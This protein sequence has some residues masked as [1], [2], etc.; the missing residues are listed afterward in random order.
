MSDVSAK[1]IDAAQAVEVGGLPK[2]EK[3]RYETVTVATTI[4]GSWHN[5]TMYC[6]TDA[7][8]HTFSDLIPIGFKM[9]IENIATAGAA[10][11]SIKGSATVAIIGRNQ[12]IGGT[13]SV[14]AG[15]VGKKLVNTKGTAL[16]YDYVEVE[17][18]SSTE[19]RAT[20]YGIWAKEV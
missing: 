10:D 18:I 2:I 9:R 17:K 5:G 20:S 3:K 16:K 1:Y 13:S 11:L 19:I 15:A 12:V 4:D 8:V 14:I 6:A 7:L